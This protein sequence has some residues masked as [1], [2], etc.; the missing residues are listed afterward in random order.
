[1]CR[2]ST[3]GEDFSPVPFGI[4]CIPEGELQLP[5]GAGTPI[6]VA[7]TRNGYVGCA[8]VIFQMAQEG[9]V[10]VSG[11]GWVFP[12]TSSRLTER[13]WWEWVMLD[14][15]LSRTLRAT[16]RLTSFDEACA[17]LVTAYQSPER[18]GVKVSEPCGGDYSRSKI[19]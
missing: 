4:N 18:Y 17:D 6:Y 1:M 3:Y 8:D 14:G 7:C 19:G 9:D 2:I 13:L 16:E 5:P 15:T 10:P 11:I 12:A